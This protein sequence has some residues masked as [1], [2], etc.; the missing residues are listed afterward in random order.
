MMHEYSAMIHEYSAM[1]YEYSA[2]MH[3][4]SA[5]MHECSA[6]IHEY[7]ALTHPENQR[8][9]V[10]SLRP[11]KAGQIGGPEWRHS[12]HKLA[13]ICCALTLHWGLEVVEECINNIVEECINNIV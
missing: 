5:M 2:M 4:C 12:G 11:P 6:M 1:M 7:S 9:L 13:L 8:Q 3:E 10:F